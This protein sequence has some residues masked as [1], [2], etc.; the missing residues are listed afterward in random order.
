M[1]ARCPCM[2]VQLVYYR[3]KIRAH[4]SGFNF[5][6]LGKE[7]IYITETRL[8][9][10]CVWMSFLD[11]HDVTALNLRDL[12]PLH[13]SS[14]NKTWIRCTASLEN[15]RERMA[16]NHNYWQLTSKQ[17]RWESWAL[18]E[19]SVDKERVRDRER[20]RGG[21]SPRARES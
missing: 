12:P 20:A 21:A 6:E 2:P 7:N 18:R 19:I 1:C 9:F 13:S 8:P 15:L 4:I 11:S 3:R 16:I 5:F 17:V 14:G 10:K